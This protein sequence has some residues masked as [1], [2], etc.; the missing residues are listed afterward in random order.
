MRLVAMDWCR[1][2][3]AEAPRFQGG[4]CTSSIP[5]LTTKPHDKEAATMPT[6]HVTPGSDLLLQDIAN[7]LFKA[8]KVVVVTGA[9][10]STNS[11]I[12]VS[13]TRCMKHGDPS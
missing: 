10:I 9:G 6:V 7:S 5:I 2:V 8:K 13:R 1:Q 12:P 11:G 3:D 4:A